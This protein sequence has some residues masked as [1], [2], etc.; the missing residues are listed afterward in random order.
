MHVSHNCLLPF[1]YIKPQLI[2]SVISG[3]PIVSYLFSTSNHNHVSL[4]VRGSSIVSYL[5]STSNHNSF[6]PFGAAGVLSLTFFL[7]QTTTALCAPTGRAALSLTF[8][9]HQTTTDDGVLL[10][11]VSLSLTFFLHQTTTCR[12]SPRT[13]GDCL[14][15]F[16]YIK[17]QPVTS[18]TVVQPIVSYLFSTSNHNLDATVAE[19]PRL[20]LTFFLHQTTTQLVVL[21]SHA[22]C[23]L[24]FFYIK[25]QPRR[26]TPYNLTIVSYLFSTSNHNRCV[27]AVAEPPLSLT[28]FLHQTTTEW[29]NSSLSRQLS[30]TFFLHQTTTCFCCWYYSFYCLLPFF[31]IKPQR[32][33]CSNVW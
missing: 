31:Y 7:H 26:L 17:P 10:G 27:V 16:F 18:L 32:S 9:L 20:S 19:H 22:N 8:F 3:L 23:L 2:H 4:V 5:F 12:R 21:L 1:F 29:K 11:V 33:D 30:L 14:L 13:R 15:P 28:F 6:A 25:P 24:P